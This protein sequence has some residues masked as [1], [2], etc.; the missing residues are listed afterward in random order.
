M[1]HPRRMLAAAIAGLALTGCARDATSLP[2]TALLDALAAGPYTLESVNGQPLPVEV[3]RDATVRVAVSDGTLSFS[4]TGFSQHLTL[5]EA[6][7]GSVTT[8]RQSST[9]GAV[10]ISG[11]RIHF[12]ATDGGEWDGV[13]GP[14]RLEYSVA[15]NNGALVFSFRR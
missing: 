2:S 15:G 3:R 12:R 10:T 5:W 6:V 7:P 11:E 4:G 13:L 1:M 14:G 8:P 9:Q